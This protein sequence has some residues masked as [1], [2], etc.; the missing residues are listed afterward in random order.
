MNRELHRRTRR[1]KGKQVW[2][3]RFYILPHVFRCWRL[4]TN[5][6]DFIY[7]IFGLSQASHCHILLKNCTSHSREIYLAMGASSHA[8]DV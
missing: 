7:S 5:K 8:L 3:Q 6:I 2:M 1:E 4:N